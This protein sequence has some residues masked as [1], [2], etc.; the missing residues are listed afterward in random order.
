M[1]QPTRSTIEV[2]TPIEI[3]SQ[4]VLSEL[5]GN[6]IRVG[7]EGTGW[8]LWSLYRSEE[9]NVKLRPAKTTEP[10][11]WS[12]DQLKL[13]MSDLSSFNEVKIYSI[14]PAKITVVLDS[15]AQ[16]ILPIYLPHSVE[17][18]KGYSNTAP[19]GIN[20]KSVT[21]S[22]PKSKIT[23]LNRW[24]LDSVKFT[25]VRQ[26]INDSIPLKKAQE[27]DKVMNLSP[28]TVQYSLPVSEITELK[29]ICQIEAPSDSLSLFPARAVVRVS[30]PIDK[31]KEAQDYRI[32]LGI[33]WGNKRI[34]SSVPVKIKGAL[35]YWM[36]NVRI[37]P[38]SVDYLILDTVPNTEK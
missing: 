30:V 26:N 28:K 7:V 22:G 23:S 33:E 15:A 14:N 34:G 18:A 13:K 19:L 16:K 38:P 37:T 25:S 29:K 17:Y 8:Q 35:P 21:V 1:S 24:T 9:L 27:Y 6:S 20:P 4:F 12:S 2:K 10:Q 3:P 32:E 31:Y 11:N 5:T 36:K